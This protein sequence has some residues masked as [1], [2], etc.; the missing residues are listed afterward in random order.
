METKPQALERPAWAVCPRPTDEGNRAKWFLD[1]KRAVQWQHEIVHPATISV[2]E[3]ARSRSGRRG[4]SRMDVPVR[5]V[6][7]QDSGGYGWIILERLDGEP[8]RQGI[9]AFRY[10]GGTGM[11]AL[12]ELG[13]AE[14]PQDY[15]AEVR[16]RDQGWKYLVPVDWLGDQLGSSH[17]GRRFR[18]FLAP[19]DIGAEQNSDLEA[20]LDDYSA[21]RA[22][23]LSCDLGDDWQFSAIEAAASKLEG[24]SF[25]G[26][27]IQSLPHQ[28]ALI[29]WDL[30]NALVQVHG[31]LS[32][33]ALAAF[34]TSW[35]LWRHV[36]E[37]A[38]S[39]CE[40]LNR[41]RAAAAVM[42][43]RPALQFLY[44]QMW[45]YA[46][47]VDK[48]AAESDGWGGLRD[49]GFWKSL[50]D[51]EFWFQQGER[52]ERSD[53][54]VYSKCENQWRAAGD[55]DTGSFESEALRA[56]QELCSLGLTVNSPADAVPAWLNLLQTN[57]RYCTR[58]D[59]T[60]LDP[61][62]QLQT[63]TGGIIR[64]T[65][66][67]S[68]SCCTALAGQA[69]RNCMPAR[70][71]DGRRAN[72]KQRRRT[73]PAQ[74]E[75][76]AMNLELINTWIDDQGYTNQELGGELNISVRAVSSLRS[77]GRC[78]GR[79]AAA[80]LANRMGRALSDLYLS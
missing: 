15:R 33:A 5:W 60:S 20:D 30:E 22:A 13:L 21:G 55:A 73:R 34:W 8:I 72:R 25:R 14:L 70:S 78:H 61:A 62:G 29:T 31:Q 16:R 32:A 75:G 74:G 46:Q 26:R 19:E 53:D 28:L 44:R 38:R 54:H 43:S 52:F 79:N 17:S 42:D 10:S 56:V 27:A 39:V 40:E 45:A 23:Q 4:V 64:S 11:A 66:Q 12:S 9:G 49:A 47:E 2:K 1:P 76:T 67:A 18:D 59:F 35:R 24:H 77:G 51:A 37:W 65:R 36:A 69:L 71:P 68:V 6:H 63:A 41:Q 57:P 3:K 48:S 7:R 50:R 58:P 80:K